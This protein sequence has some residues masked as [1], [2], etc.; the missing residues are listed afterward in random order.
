MFKKILYIVSESQEEKRLVMD[1]ARSGDS[2][3]L[4]SAL[5]AIG[6]NPQVRTEGRT[7]ERVVKE[8]RERQCW[9]DLYELEEEFKAAG[10]K[11]SVMAR[12]GGV[13]DIHALAHNTGADLIILSAASLAS[14][15]YRLPDEFLANLPCPILIVNPT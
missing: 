10:I 13:A 2:A 12:E 14:A 3:V 1:L 15:N 4:L 7:H 11:S 5:F 9:H 8:D 6:C